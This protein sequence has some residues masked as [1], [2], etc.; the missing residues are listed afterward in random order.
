MLFIV[1][2]LVFLLIIPFSL[3]EINLN[4]LAK[5]IYNKGDL[6]KVN[7]YVSSDKDQSSVALAMFLVCDNNELQFKTQRINVQAG[8]TYPISSEVTIPFSMSGDCQIRVNF[9][10][11]QANS[12]LFK[13]TKGLKGSFTLIPLSAQ[14]GD[15]ITLTGTITKLNGDL[16]NGI[17][18][19]YI[20]K[21]DKNYL[22]SSIQIK[23]SKFEFK[24][25]IQSIPEGPYHI[26]L[27]VNDLFG[28]EEFF[29]NAATLNV[30][31]RF[32]VNVL[33]DKQ[34]Y[35]PED[36]IKIQ[37]AVEKTVGTKIGSAEA[38]FILDENEYSTDV[39]NNKFEFELPLSS[40]IK[41]YNHDLRV[42]I[43]DEFGNVGEKI[44]RV[45]V[46]PNEIKLDSGLDKEFFTPKEIITFKP[47]LYDQAAD[48]IQE[49]VLLKI[50]DSK[51]KE[52]LQ[53]EIPTNDE[54]NFKLNQF[55]LPGTWSYELKSKKLNVRGSFT[56]DTIEDIQVLLQGQILKVKNIGNVDYDQKLEIT[57]TDLKDIPSILYVRTG[58]KPSE[59][60]SYPLYK[61]LKPG[62]YDI[63]VA[64][65]GAKFEDVNVV[66]SRDLPGKVTDFLKQATG[67]A[68]GA[69]GTSNNYKPL[70]FMLLVLGAIVLLLSLSRFR[71]KARFEYQRERERRLGQRTLQKIQSAPEYK[72]RFGKATQE[73]VK[74]FKQRMLKDIQD[75]N[76]RKQSN[77]DINS[78]DESV[79]G[80]IERKIIYDRYKRE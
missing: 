35:N 42:T 49:S 21:D 32:K 17:G 54:F 34:Q 62:T 77:P 51:N 28:N 67:A 69:S 38:K 5:T 22:T 24:T 13:I 19:L 30:Y 48:T 10:D 23:D 39:V 44:I 64:N 43:T 46:T 6:L 12:E 25:K 59:E 27:A 36:T 37:G 9:G 61:D 7:G 74:D 15:D 66:D 60:L 14:L 78:R 40:S 41:S 76:V 4:P 71:K 8:K 52:V 16:I 68:I 57:A 18:T 56:V 53:K 75:S 11:E 63:Y 65:K 29:W 2:S 73:D 20:E 1:L 72:P 47:R 45:Y 70:A 3:A 33:L 55:A 50:S 79:R 31:D 26:N 80:S 58:I